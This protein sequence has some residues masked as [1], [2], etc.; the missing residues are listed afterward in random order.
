MRDNAGLNNV[1]MAYDAD[2][3]IAPAQTAAFAKPHMHHEACSV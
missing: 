1:K 3:Q 2:I